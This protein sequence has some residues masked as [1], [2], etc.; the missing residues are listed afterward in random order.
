MRRERNRRRD[1]KKT[2]LQ[3]VFAMFIVAQVFLAPVTIKINSQQTGM[4][5]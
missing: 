2:A 3:S 4:R 1:R 5:N